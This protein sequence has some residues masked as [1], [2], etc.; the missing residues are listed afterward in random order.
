[1]FIYL[2]FFIIVDRKSSIKIKQNLFVPIFV[3][4]IQHSLWCKIEKILYKSC[5]LCL[6]R[7]KIIYILLGKN[8]SD[9][10]QITF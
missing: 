5:F 1:M 4:G 8:V 6:E 10:E 3:D 2:F 7:I 9:F